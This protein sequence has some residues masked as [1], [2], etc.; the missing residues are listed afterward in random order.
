MSTLYC[1]IYFYCELVS[2]EILFCPQL[3]HIHNISSI[4]LK[5]N[6]FSQFNG[7]KYSYQYK[8]LC[9]LK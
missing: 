7:F 6:L 1:Y 4:S 5:Y 3:E 8:R 9:S 2:K